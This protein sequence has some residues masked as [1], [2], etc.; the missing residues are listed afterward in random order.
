VP[1]G[2]ER[3]VRVRNRRELTGEPRPTGV[4][5]AEA[6]AA[7][8]PLLEKSTTTPHAV[9]ACLWEGYGYLHGAV[10][11]L[12]ADGVPGG[13]FS[14]PALPVEGLPRLHLPHRAYYVFRGAVPAVVG[15]SLL[16]QPR[17]IGWRDGPNLWWPE[18][19]AWFVAS[20]I[21]LPSSYIGCAAPL[22]DALLVDERVDA[23]EVAPT[24]VDDTGPR[25]L[26]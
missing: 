22:A 21:D 11:G 26:A 24:S 20:E 2:Y 15:V 7:V 4:I 5:A 6:L 13:A 19:R 16:A 14:A 8:A 12:S 10:A 23:T 3:Y 9:W 18:D 25:D 17:E 1:S